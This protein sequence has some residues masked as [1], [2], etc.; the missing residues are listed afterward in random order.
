MLDVSNYSTKYYD[1]SN[2][3]IIGKMKDETG[4]VTIEE[5]VGLKPKMYSFLVNNTENKKEKFVNRNS[6]SATGLNEYKDELLN[7]KFIRHLMN[8]IQST[9]HRTGT[10]EINKVSLFFF[11]DKIY[12]QNNGYDGLAPAY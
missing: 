7:N 4:S 12:I 2:K 10:Y 5:F 3:L 8:R 9:D 11:Y 6:D 1:I